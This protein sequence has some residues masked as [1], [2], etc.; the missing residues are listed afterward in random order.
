M[1]SPSRHQDAVQ[2]AQ[3]RLVRGFASDFGPQKVP[4]GVQNRSKKRTKSV[5]TNIFVSDRVLEPNFIDFAVRKTSFLGPENGPKIGTVF[6]PGFCVFS[7]TSSAFWPPALRGAAARTL[8]QAGSENLQQRP[9]QLSESPPHRLFLGPQ[10][11][12][13]FRTALLP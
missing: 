11:G 8:F 13:Y 7:R 1:S 12:P 6:G 9:E 5:S 4:Q 10:S 2:G 3:G